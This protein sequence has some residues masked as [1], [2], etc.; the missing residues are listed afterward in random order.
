M[1]GIDKRD[2]R[3]FTLL[4]IM[5]AVAIV[6]MFSTIVGV[7]VFNRYVEA[8]K[9]AAKVQI[10]NIEAALKH[11]RRHCFQYPGTDQGLEALINTPSVGR[12]C[13]NWE[14]PYLDSKRVPL[15]PWGNP[16]NYISDGKS[17]DI[18]SYGPD[19][20]SGGGDDIKSEEME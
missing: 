9:N 20:Q 2:E 3:G 14:G 18:D 5:I 13:E 7:A 8:Q 1:Q 4:E 10:Q 17:F 15:D 19:G 12:S 16:Y 6:V 11:Y